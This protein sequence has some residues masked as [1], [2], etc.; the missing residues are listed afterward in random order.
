MTKRIEMNYLDFLNNAHP[1]HIEFNKLNFTDPFIP[2]TESEKE[3]LIEEIKEM[4][5][6]YGGDS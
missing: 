5:T 2:L 4:N 3:D 6:L 1:N